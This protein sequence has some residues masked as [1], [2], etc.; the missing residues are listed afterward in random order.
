[1]TSTIK[2][3]LYDEYTQSNLQVKRIP[4]N[5]SKEWH[6]TSGG[7]LTHRTNRF[8][9]VVGVRYYSVSEDMYKSQPIIDQPEI[10]LLS[11]LVTKKSDEWWI[12]AHAKI[13][14]GNVNGAQ[15]APTIQATKSNYEMAHGGAKTPYLDVFRS[16]PNKLCD[17][18]QSE[19]NSRFLAK[20]NRNCVVML[21]N[22]VDELGS[23]FKWIPISKLVALLND[24]YTINSDARSVLACWLF[25]DSR[26]MRE[27]SSTS[28]GFAGQLANSLESSNALHCDNEIEDWLKGLN[29]KWQTNADT[30]SLKKLKGDW[31]CHDSEIVS[32]ADPSLLIYHI[33]VSC[34][35][36]EVTQWDQPISGSN[37]KTEL[38][39]FISQHKGIMHLLLQAK[40][41]AGN[42]SG[43]ELTTTVQAEPSTVSYFE[44]K[45]IT[46]LK[47]VGK[48]LLDIHN[49]EEGG[50]FDQCI[51]RYRVVWINET[52]EEL[53]GPFHRWISLQQFSNY[54][55]KEKF[56][57]NELRSAVSCLLCIKNI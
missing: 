55:K 16:I 26:A 29:A 12:L 19:Q 39:L 57:T 54:L 56:T 31:T 53:E 17:Q 47:N 34:R 9:N 8:F 49:S 28:N 48:T 22:K 41:E 23:Q 14:P 7:F 33:D 6:W 44:S 18:L 25:S 37:T 15:L 43:F 36:R 50:R 35:N 21:D 11:F 2:T 30:I 10:G 24:D 32:T 27:C 38:I 13:E 42:R 4:F 46:F 1:M 3:W 45:Y 5:Q 52:S 40:L 51:C 20:R